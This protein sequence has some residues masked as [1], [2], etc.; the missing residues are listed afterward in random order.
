M[1]QIEAIPVTHRQDISF[2][3][4]KGV[5]GPVADSQRFY[6]LFSTVASL[7]ASVIKATGGNPG[8]VEKY[9]DLFP[10]ESRMGRLGTSRQA[11]RWQRLRDRWGLRSKPVMVSKTFA[12]TS[13]RVTTLGALKTRL[14]KW[15]K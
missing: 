8:K 6:L 12:G 15:L 1:A 5:L 11:L 13:G 3:L 9:E 2:L 4:A 7:L 10:T 14:R